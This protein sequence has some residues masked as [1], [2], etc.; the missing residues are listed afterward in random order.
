MA[1]RYAIWNKID[2]IYTPGGK[3]YTATEWADKYEWI[4]C[5]DTVPVV[6][7]GKINGGYLGELFQMKEQ[8][9]AE[10]ATFEEDLLNEELLDAIEDCYEKRQIASQNAALEPTSEE[11]IAA[12]LEYQNLLATE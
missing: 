10:G 2:D 5:T 8:C 1:K 6:G 12:A 11:R 9:E 7:A 4:K 3:K